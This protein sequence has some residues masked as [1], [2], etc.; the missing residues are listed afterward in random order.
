MPR[1]LRTPCPEPGCSKL[2]DGGRCAAHRQQARR[3]RG[4]ARAK[5]YD[6]RH[7]ER[8]RAAV[9]ARDPVC[10][11]CG[12]APSL[13][14]DHWPRSRKELV[15]AGLDANDPQYG[16]GLCKTCDSKQTARRQPGGWHAERHGR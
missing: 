9:L 5:G 1:R 15:A 8:F 12:Q 11:M 16:R 6:G 14:A 10:V 3:I 2:T 13:V 4:S 7:E